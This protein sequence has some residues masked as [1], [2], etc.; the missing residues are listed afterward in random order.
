MPNC[1]FSGFDLIEFSL[2]VDTFES[3]S[4]TGRESFVVPRLRA[5]L[6][7]GAWREI[8][9]PAICEW[10]RR[11]VTIV[12]DR[13]SPS[14][15]C[16]RRRHRCSPFVRAQKIALLRDDRGGGGGEDSFSI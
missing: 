13:I 6:L 1:F 7:R 5:L 15:P 12:N 14:L 9:I 16:R 11:R 4:S 8:A 3:G 2:S 10:R